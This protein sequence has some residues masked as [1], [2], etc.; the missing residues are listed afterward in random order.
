MRALAAAVAASIVLGCAA[1]EADR[2][3]GR[4]VGASGEIESVAPTTAPWY[5]RARAIDLTGDGQADSVRL[6][7][8]G[9]RPDSLRITLALIVDGVAKH[10]EVWGSGYELALTDSARGRGPSVE[11]LL[12]ARLDSVLSGVVVQRL[13][14]P[15]VR[16]MAEDDAILA[17]LEP[18]PTHRISFSYGYETTV[19]L[20]WDATGRRFVRLWSCC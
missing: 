13:D 16:T 2:G 11:A 17:D 5:R 9:A 19:R 4:D 15:G 12:R 14:D 1:G 18:R 8:V 10:R 3:P 6:E 7:A 20:V